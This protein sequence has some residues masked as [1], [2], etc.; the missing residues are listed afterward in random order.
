MKRVYFIQAN[1]SY[2][3][4]YYLPY[5]TGCLAAYAWQYE[6]IKSEYTIGEFIF[7]REP[8]E[9]I[10]NRIDN[11][12]VVAF[13]C[14][15]WTFEYNKKLAA[16]VKKRFP[17][18]LIIFGGHSISENVDVFPELPFVDVLMYGEGEIDFKAL[19]EQF[20]TLDKDF[21]SIPNIAYRKGNKIFK[22]ERKFHNNLNGFLSPY[23][24]GYFDD[25]ITKNPHQEFCAVVETNRGCPYNCAYCDWCYTTDIRQFPIEKV[26]EEIIWCSKNKIE[27]IFCADSN[28]GILKRDLD[29]AKFVVELKKKTGFPHI[30]N[31]CFAK[32]S[33]D[34]VFEI[35]KLFYDNKINKAATLAYQTVCDTALKNVNRKNFTMEAFSDLVTKYNKHNIPTYT[36]MILGLPGETYDSFCEG[37]CKLIEA[38]QQTALTVY[39][40]QVYP[41]SL[42][43]KKEY[44]NLHGI[45]TARV[46]LNYLHSSIPNDDDITEY[47]ELI[48]ATRDMPFCDMMK[49]IMFCT[50]LQCFHHI[51]LLKYF[52]IYV[53]KELNISYLEFYKRLL[54]FIFNSKGTFLN[55][56]FNNFREQCSDFSKGEWSYYNEKFGEIGW[57]LEEGAFMEIVSD[58][59]VFWNEI[60]PFLKEF[61]IDEAIFNE[62]TAFQKFVIRLPK[63]EKISAEFNYD[64]YTYFHNALSSNY[65]PLKERKNIIEVNLPTSVNNWKDYARKVVLFAKRRGDTI[66]INDKKY[67][68]ITYVGE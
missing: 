3:D 65:A 54:D 15:T 44:Q 11:P 4:A 47:T 7:K 45:E 67:L 1:L 37:L 33:N 68:K 41:N 48:V 6:T 23:L 60:I 61:K 10:I 5:A 62:L 18:C 34:T 26:K 24:E 12:S 64:F 35:S 22:T 21:S 56:L 46:P 59:E 9:K 40:C 17:E 8:I 16:A 42:M 13:S 28:F 27:Y 63:K 50:C 20:N 51:G 32:N 55:E 30:F 43:G 38:G 57:F 19:L 31:N 52:S 36:E 53:R 2:G 39:Y 29:I 14:Y 66:I 49:S 25:I 58:Y